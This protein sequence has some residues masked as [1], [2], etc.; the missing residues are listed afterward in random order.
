[1]E[2]RVTVTQY[3]ADRIAHARQVNATLPADSPER[4]PGS[5]QNVSVIRANSM[6]HMPNFF[7][8]GQLSKIFFLFPDPHFKHRK[9][10]ARIV[11][12][13][14]LAEY[15]YVLRPGGILYT[16]TDVKGELEMPERVRE[17]SK[18]EAWWSSHGQGRAAAVR[19]WERRT[20]EQDESR[21]TVER[22]RAQQH[23]HG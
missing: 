9:Q 5:L 8:Q 22:E 20:P 18:G 15:A 1:M 12:T 7:A 2:I 17:D 3:V 19:E 6:K 16:V 21:R 13:P 4:Q 10:K 11:T 23:C 14:L